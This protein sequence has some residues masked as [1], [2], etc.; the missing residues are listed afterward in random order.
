MC[1][2]RCH[3]WKQTHGA[4]RPRWLDPVRCL[5]C[6]SAIDS[7]D[8]RLKYCNETCRR[9]HAAGSAVGK[10]RTCGQCGATFEVKNGKQRYCSKPCRIRANKGSGSSTALRRSAEARGAERGE[11]FT[12]EDVCA[13]DG[14]VCGLCIGPIDPAI[15]GDRYLEGTVDHIVPISAGGTHT[16]DNVQP[17]HWTCNA[18][19]R[20]STDVATMSVPGPWKRVIARWPD[21]APDRRTRAAG[22][23]RTRTRSLPA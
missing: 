5:Y 11:R 10:T 21:A 6:D 15:R 22:P 9:R 23:E 17:A 4:A 12:L 16:M 7:P 18:A 14:W 3:N 20:N 13:R 2:R 8:I 19:K 1:S